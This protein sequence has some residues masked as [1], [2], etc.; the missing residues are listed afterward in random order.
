MV[1][2]INNFIEEYKQK[3]LIKNALCTTGHSD[4][5]EDC[6][7]KNI[8]NILKSSISLRNLHFL[9]ELYKKS[10][11]TQTDKLFLERNNNFIRINNQEQK[12]LINIY[13][14]EKGEWDFSI[15]T[16]GFES[17]TYDK[18]ILYYGFNEKDYMEINEKFIN[19]NKTLLGVKQPWELNSYY[20]KNVKEI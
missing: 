16:D 14:K 8:Q 6:V 20:E 2:K 11:L 3:Y 10:I 19:H 9:D 4:E 17:D 18:E 7:R 1:F 15:A 12:Y 13:I 5:Q